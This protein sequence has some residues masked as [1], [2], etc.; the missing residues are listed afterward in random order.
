MATRNALEWFDTCL[1]QYLLERERGHF[2]QVVADVFGYNAM[3]IGF[4]QYDFLRSNRMPLQFC[5]ALEEGA[6][7]RAAPEFLPIETNSLDLVL[8][9]HVLEFSAN[10]HQILREVQRVLMPEGHVI[11]CGFNPRSLW[12]MRRILGSVGARLPWRGNLVSPHRSG[13]PSAGE[14][15]P[16][17]G[18][19]IAL[20]RL[21]DWLT[22]L[23]FEITADRLCCYAPPFSQEK[24]LRRAGFMEAAGERWWPFSGGIYFLTAVKRVHGM[25]V[26][27]PE[28]KEVRAA[29]RG[30]A[31]IAQK[32]G[33]GAPEDGPRLAA[34][35]GIA[36][37]EAQ[38][39]ATRGRRMRA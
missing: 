18:R 20:P 22:L 5:A 37:T 29:R 14:G 11:V 16:W 4:P 39:R 6:A 23:D 38:A 1:G 3:Q 12:G 13:R 34:R 31:P 24:W 15:F 26:I 30:M 25:R 27:K 10:P 36:P 7:L 19:F 35:A 17:H 9:P 33:G 21:K 32:L 8:L 2:D 28:W